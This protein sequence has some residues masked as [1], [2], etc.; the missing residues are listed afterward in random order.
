MS[1]ALSQV[2]VD[3]RGGEGWPNPKPWSILP[4]VRTLVPTLTANFPE[5]LARLVI[6]PV[7]WVATAVWSAAS[8][9]LDERT[10]AKCQMISGAADRKAPIP[11][12]I[13]EFVDEAV[14]LE[15]TRYR[16]ASICGEQCATAREAASTAPSAADD[17]LASKAAALELS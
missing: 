9:L 12:G 10:S 16:D 8:S 4:W 11:S 2:L 1:C 3:A 5:R 13:S 7:P 15:V 6:Y 17:G 14:V